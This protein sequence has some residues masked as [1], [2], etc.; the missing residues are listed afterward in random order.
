MELYLE[1]PFILPVILCGFGKS[2]PKKKSASTLSCRYKLLLFTFPDEATTNY[3][4]IKPMR[5]MSMWIM[6]LSLIF[7]CNPVYS[8]K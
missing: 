5:Q 1:P 3:L 6:C 4:K 2:F 8:Y 7:L